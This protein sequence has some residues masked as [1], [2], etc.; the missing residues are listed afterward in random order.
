[1]KERK[2]NLQMMDKQNK[3][4]KWTELVYKKKVEKS[5]FKM[6]GKNIT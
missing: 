4:W 5:C 6:S 2:S 1:M 3:I